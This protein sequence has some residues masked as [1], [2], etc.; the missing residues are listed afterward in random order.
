M[1]YDDGW[2]LGLNLSSGQHPPPKGCFPFDCLG[3]VVNAGAGRPTSTGLPMPVPVALQ[4]GTPTVS[5]SPPPPNNLS[6]ETSN[7]MPIPGSTSDEA[8]AQK[9]VPAP[10]QPVNPALVPLPPPTPSSATGQSFPAG[11]TAIPRDSTASP[12]P[13]TASAVSAEPPQ[14]G[15][16]TGL[17]AGSPLS[18]NFP[19]S[20]GSGGLS[21]QQQQERRDALQVKGMKRASSLIASRD[22]DLFVALGEVL[23]VQQRRQ[24]EG[25]SLL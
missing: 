13:S 19:E 20:T 6:N 7:L 4:P 5:V 14:L 23:Y 9:R 24:D 11:A 3:Q 10:L 8:L 17:S 1:K 16:L 12:A 2:A 18:A 21:A 15:P 25:K 22:A